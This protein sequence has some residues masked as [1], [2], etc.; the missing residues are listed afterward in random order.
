MLMQHFGSATIDDVLHTPIQVV[1]EQGG[2]AASVAVA[3]S[4][5]V[6]VF[7]EDTRM[8][9]DAIASDL[10]TVEVAGYVRQAQECQ[11]S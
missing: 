3:T 2:V 4:F 9:F 7:K 5:Q 1:A 11:G 8:A 10:D 6:S